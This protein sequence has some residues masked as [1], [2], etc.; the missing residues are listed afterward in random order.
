M[1]PFIIRRLLYM[2]VVLLF[3]IAITFLIFYILPS[4]DPAALRAG[5]SP[6]PET[7]AAIRAQL[8]PDGR[9]EPERR[10]ETGGARGLHVVALAFTGRWPGIKACQGWPSASCASHAPSPFTSSCTSVWACPAS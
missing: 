10:Y 2:V 3:V 7:L 4:A 9:I 8:G 5:R 6:T 1:G